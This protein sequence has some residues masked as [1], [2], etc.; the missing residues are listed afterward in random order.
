M[1]TQETNPEIE[2]QT[3]IPGE[4]QELSEEELRE[5]VEKAVKSGREEAK[6]I[7]ILHQEGRFGGCGYE[8]LWK[9]GVYSILRGEVEEIELSYR[10]NENECYWKRDVALIPK[11]KKVIIYIENKDENPEYN[12]CDELLVFVYPTGWRR[13]KLC[14]GTES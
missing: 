3:E 9:Y 2:T 13:I 14:N 7:Y 6:L 1:A 12:V 5:L 10:R 4:T 8:Y 11:T